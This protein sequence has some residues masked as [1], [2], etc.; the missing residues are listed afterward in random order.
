MPSTPFQ[1]WTKS[2][3]EKVLND[4]PW[5]QLHEVRIKYQGQVQ[6]VAGSSSGASAEANSRGRAE[7][8]G[9]HPPVDC[10]FTVRLRSGL[11]VREALLRIK[12]LDAKYDKLNQSERA[13]FDSKYKG[14]L[15][16]PA[17]AQNYVLT[18][19]SKSKSN[20]GADAVFTL[21]N[22]ARLP[23]LQRYVFIAN[24]KGEQ[25]TV[26]HVIP[27]RV[28]GDEAMFFFPRYDPGGRLLFTP[29][30]KELLFNL[31]N[32]EVNNISNFRIDVSRLVQ[33]NQVLF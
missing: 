12:Q 15:E 27:P 5:V 26:I 3:A 6:A 17:C 14:L 21:F 32:N 28:P 20:P 18:L 31:A 13:A 29:E 4:S 10:V 25:R 9:P 16:C 7:L 1:Q 22:G 19:S 30:S 8:G 2:E 33:N 11:P 23:D 24:D